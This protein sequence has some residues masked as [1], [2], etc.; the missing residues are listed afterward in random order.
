MEHPEHELN[1]LR[2]IEQQMRRQVFYLRKDARAMVA[3]EPGALMAGGTADGLLT[4]AGQIE[5][6]LDAG[7]DAAPPLLAEIAAN[8]ATLNDLMAEVTAKVSDDPEFTKLATGQLRTHMTA[9][10]YKPG[11]V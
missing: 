7:K 9:L 4:A 10:G 8:L 2:W 1:R 6:I 3:A 5:R 11:W